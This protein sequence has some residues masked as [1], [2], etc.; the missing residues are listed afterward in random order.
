MRVKE[1]KKSDCL[2]THFHF[3]W[4]CVGTNSGHS[5]RFQT[6]FHSADLVATQNTL[7]G[8][9]ANIVNPTLLSSSSPKENKVFR[10]SKEAPPRV[11]WLGV[12]FFSKVSVIVTL[13]YILTWDQ[14]KKTNENTVIITIIVIKPFL[15]KLCCIRLN[16][17]VKTVASACR[18]VVATE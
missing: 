14:R 8:H 12:M 1:I 5:T 15:L 17:L 18:P 3:C 6:I 9:A 11:S 2:L 16:G 10:S 4:C 7:L 13:S